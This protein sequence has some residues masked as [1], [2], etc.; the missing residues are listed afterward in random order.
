M[1]DKV[2]D[3]DLLITPDKMIKLAGREIIYKEM[4]SGKSLKAVEMYQKAIGEI[5]GEVVNGKKDTDILSNIKLM[6]RYQNNIIDLC[7]F[8]LKPEFS[9][10]NWLKYGFLKRKWLYRNATVKQLEMFIKEVMK[11]ILGEDGAGKLQTA[12][13]ILKG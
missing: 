4:P 5:T 6:K 2:T 7:L 12:E 11:P 10:K 8:I 3:L 9:F 1:S 13:G